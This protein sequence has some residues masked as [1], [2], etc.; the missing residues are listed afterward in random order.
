MQV[1]AQA[2]KEVGA[3]LE[4]YSFEVESPR[5]HQCSLEVEYC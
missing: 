3:K 1:Q 4:P 2:A 5:E